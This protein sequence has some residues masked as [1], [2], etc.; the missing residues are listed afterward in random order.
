[1]FYLL[2]LKLTKDYVE[3]ITTFSHQKVTYPLCKHHAMYHNEIAESL[4]TLST[5]SLHYI[6]YN[7]TVNNIQEC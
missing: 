3:D 1:M 6:Y 2:E 4:Q 7:E 5:V